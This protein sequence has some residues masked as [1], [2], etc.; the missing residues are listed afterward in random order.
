MLYDGP[1]AKVEALGG[2][3]SFFLCKTDG[4]HKREFPKILNNRRKWN[5][6]PPKEAFSKM[7]TQNP[8]GDVAFGQPTNGNP[9]KELSTL[10]KES[11]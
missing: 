10:N 9:N 3:N 1:N 11:S 4:H 2:L 8:T 6:N 7:E 5:P